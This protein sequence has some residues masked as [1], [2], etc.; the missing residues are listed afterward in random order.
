[1]SGTPVG[2]GPYALRPDAE[3]GMDPNPV[4]VTAAV[5]VP[6]TDTVAGTGTGTAA[7]GR[8]PRTVFPAPIWMDL[9]LF[10]GVGVDVLSPLVLDTFPELPTLDAVAVDTDPAATA[11]DDEVPR[12]RLPDDRRACPLEELCFEEGRDRQLRDDED[13]EWPCRELRVLVDDD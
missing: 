7:P 12:R 2:G 6:D 1:V 10:N 11:A 4:V 9:E 13:D 5:A 8:G 3:R